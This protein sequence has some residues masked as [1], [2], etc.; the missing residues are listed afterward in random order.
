MPATVPRLCCLVKIYD[1]LWNHLE[2]GMKWS[3]PEG[4]LEQ[5]PREQQ[6]VLLVQLTHNQ[7]QR[8]RRNGMVW[9][10]MGKPDGVTGRGGGA[11]DDRATGAGAMDAA[12]AAC[13]SWSSDVAGGCDRTGQ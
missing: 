9:Y 13:S 5:A 2:G 11:V 3:W 8:Y 10:V 6:A 7:S 4:R 12:R 1:S